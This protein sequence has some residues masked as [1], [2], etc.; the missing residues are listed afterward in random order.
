M[1][2]FEPGAPADL[3]ADRDFPDRNAAAAEP[4]NVPA[5]TEAMTARL[6]TQWGTG[7]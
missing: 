1:E 2:P 3:A 6:D 4:E 7:V 5:V